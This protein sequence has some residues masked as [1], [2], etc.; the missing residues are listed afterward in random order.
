MALT[1]RVTSE[2]I[3]STTEVAATR[4]GHVCGLA[5]IDRDLRFDLGAAVL[6]WLYRGSQSVSHRDPGRHSHRRDE[7]VRTL[8]RSGLELGPDTGSIA[9]LKPK[10]QIRRAQRQKKS[11]TQI[12][13]PPEL[14][15]GGAPAA[16]RLGG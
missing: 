14:R 13:K 1:W 9:D 8:D 7:W 15:G 11:K 5:R 10:S 6:A 16:A 12:K 2:P 4:F 3:R